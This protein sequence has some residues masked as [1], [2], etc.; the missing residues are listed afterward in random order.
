MNPTYLLGLKKT[1]SVNHRGQHH[2]VC[3]TCLHRA[4]FRAKATLS[5]GFYGS[6]T[7]LR[8]P[9]LTNDKFKRMQFDT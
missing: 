4:S 1:Q 3:L 9:A 5:V 2:F 6:I 7:D 8:F